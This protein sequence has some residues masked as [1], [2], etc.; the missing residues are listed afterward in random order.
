MLIR[1]IIL[2]N[3]HMMLSSS[4]RFPGIWR[5]HTIPTI[6]PNASSRICGF[7]LTSSAITSLRFFIFDRPP[8][9]TILI[10]INIKKSVTLIRKFASRKIIDP[11]DTNILAKNI[12][13]FF[14]DMT[15]T[16]SFHLWNEK[17]GRIWTYLELQWIHGLMQTSMLVAKSDTLYHQWHLK[18][19]NK[20]EITH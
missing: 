12:Q 5:T 18:T 6:L 1:Q 19:I 17:L 13:M 4:E 16:Y 2:V 8:I 15:M 14:I 9:A 3:I 10:T 11:V 7:F 20:L